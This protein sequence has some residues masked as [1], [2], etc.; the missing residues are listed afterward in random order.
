MLKKILVFCFIIS[1][2]LFF[3]SAALDQRDKSHNDRRDLYIRANLAL[4]FYRKEN[5]HIHETPKFRPFV[6]AAFGA[7]VNENFS[8]EAEVFYWK[9]KTQFRGTIGD[10]EEGNLKS[11][12]SLVNIIAHP[13]KVAW[14]GF[15][16]FVGLGL[17]YS[18]TETEDIKSSFGITNGHLGEE[19]NNFIYQIMIGSSYNMNR[20]FDIIG[21]VRW[22]DSIKFKHRTPRNNR[23]VESRGKLRS[24]AFAIGG[25]IK[26]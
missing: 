13:K 19:S 5:D 14:K 23:F 9:Q 21:D 20:Y 7:N 2:S 12:G 24:I 16:P 22:I 8:I 26:F 10:R 3:A 18:A 1:S 17:G 4:P 11:Y 25:K 6:N 15:S